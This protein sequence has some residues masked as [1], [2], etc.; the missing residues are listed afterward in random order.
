MY[1]YPFPNLPFERAKQIKALIIVWVEEQNC[2]PFLPFDLKSSLSQQGSKHISLLLEP[3]SDCEHGQF[4]LRNLY[5][6][7]CLILFLFSFISLHMLLTQNKIPVTS[8]YSNTILHLIESYDPFHNSTFSFPSL[9]ECIH[10][11][12][13]FTHPKI[14]VCI[15]LTPSNVGYP[16]ANV[17]SK[18]PRIIY[19]HNMISDQLVLYT[20][21]LL[22]FITKL[23]G[24]SLD[25]KS[26]VIWKL[27]KLNI[28][29][30]NI[31]QW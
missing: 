31:P 27:K 10:F 16:A 29:M 20:T 28:L 6:V 4:A 24:N 9:N 17:G 25:I 19:N 15:K 2:N 5:R 12:I 14:L 22:T 26:I 18:C 3:L 11:Y 23:H 7:S 13:L 21:K 8:L 1:S 30:K